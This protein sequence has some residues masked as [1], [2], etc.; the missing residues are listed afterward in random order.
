MRLD[1]KK[2]FYSPFSDDKWKSKLFILT[3]LTV[4]NVLFEILKIRV[5][6]F[7]ISCILTGYCLRFAHN[8][9]H[10]ITP[11]LPNW[12]SN[13]LKYLNYG[14]FSLIVFLAYFLLCS[15]PIY[16][17]FYL[18]KS[19]IIANIFLV[20]ISLTMVF[21]GL[22]LYCDN[23]KLKEAFNIYEFFK[24]IAKAKWE[25]FVITLI[26][27]FLGI[28]FYSIKIY[29]P[30]KTIIDVTFVIIAP[31]YSLITA[32]LIAQVYKKVKY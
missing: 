19:S 8:E 30:E 2:A 24:L 27:M 5:F 6:E 11:L 31:L 26:F 13:F 22:S 7:V 15:I 23:F 20:F 17:I 9:I 29:F 18:I 16:I 12:R 21:G 14:G 10:N 3:L 1:F 25:L 4:F 32:N 28:V